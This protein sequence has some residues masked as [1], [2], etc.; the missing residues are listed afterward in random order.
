MIHSWDYGTYDVKLDGQPL[1]RLDLYAPEV[2]PVAQK[3][4]QRELAAGTHV[5]RF[6]GAGKAEK[7]AGYYLGFD[8]LAVRVPVY[9]RAP[10]Q[11]LRK[12]QVPPS[13]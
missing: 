13:P 5:L 2:T 7:S 11:D 12:L 6:E 9:S 4:G 1:A 8:A 10:T 3:L